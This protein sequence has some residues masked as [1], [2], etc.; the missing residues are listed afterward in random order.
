MTAVTQSPDGK[1]VT[2][3]S[4]TGASGAEV[5]TVGP[6]E[7]IHGTWRDGSEL[8]MFI[9]KDRVFVAGDYT[10]FVHDSKTFKAVSVVWLPKE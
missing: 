4:E 10:Q 2:A 7:T 8:Q 9:M 6:D 1:I 3:S 5:W